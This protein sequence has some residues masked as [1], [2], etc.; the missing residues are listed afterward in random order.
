MEQNVK[1]IKDTLFKTLERL[2]DEKIKGAELCSEISRAEA[3]V[4][5]VAQI[6][7]TADTVFKAAK[8]LHD[9][10]PKNLKINEMLLTAVGVTDEKAV[11][12]DQ[13]EAIEQPKAKSQPKN[14]FAKKVGNNAPVEE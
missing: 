12:I 7:N 6:N 10:D 8:L 13:S 4:N 1:S 11:V 5:V 14:L 9:I 3:V 2:S